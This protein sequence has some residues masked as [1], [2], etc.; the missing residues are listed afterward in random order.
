MKFTVNAVVRVTER[1]SGVRV[2][3]NMLRFCD[4][5]TAAST[6]LPRSSRQSGHSCRG[7]PAA[8]RSSESGGHAQK[9][10]KGSRQ[11]AR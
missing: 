7:L 9:S 3:V 10:G 1:P 11:V 8:A 2:G 5:E 6:L 4:T